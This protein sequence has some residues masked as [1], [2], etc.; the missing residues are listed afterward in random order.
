MTVRRA[1]ALIKPAPKDRDECERY[2]GITLFSI[3]ADM[4][5]NERRNYMK[6][7]KAKRAADRLHKALRRLQVIFDDLDLHPKLLSIFPDPEKDFH[8]IVDANFLSFPN[9][10][11]YIMPRKGVTDV[12][13]NMWLKRVDAARTATGKTVRLEAE[14]KKIAA[15]YAI[16]LMQ[17]FG[18]EISAAKGSRLC[19][20][21]ALLHGQP[22]SNLSRQCG[23][24]LRRTK[25][26]SK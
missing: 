11:M 2:V 15:R 7:K 3:A 13:L 25:R 21:A 1:I 18:S 12:W 10:P 8:G 23:E 20:L 16:E 4:H 5:D 22:R 19:R 14:A 6:T 24:V 17:A 9:A 26:G